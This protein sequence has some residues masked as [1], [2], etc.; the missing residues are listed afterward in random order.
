VARFG[1]I[2]I[3]PR[4]TWPAAHRVVDRIS[5]MSTSSAALAAVTALLLW[6]L[7]AYVVMPAWWERYAKQHPSLDGLPGLT[8]TG[9]GIPG[10]PVNV[11]IAG[12]ENQ[13]RAVFTAAGWSPAD[14]L[15][16]RS[17]ARIAADAVL[18]RPY[19]DAPVSDLYLF[20]RKEDLAF[21]QAS[22]D[23]PRARHHIRFW[24]APVAHPSGAPLWLGSASFDASVGLSHTT[25]QIT[26]HISGDLDAERNHVITSL[27]A[28]GLISAV[29]PVVDFHKV[30]EGRNGG[31]D[32]WHTDGTLMLAVIGSPAAGK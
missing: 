27:E 6:A 7:T 4:A 32:P 1:V 22:G 29:I 25:G 16:L 21:E 10:D 19:A 31:G 8:Q 9:S 11:A 26:H 2:N 15:S 23:S 13:V 28:T 3:K 5:D 20:G 24:R 17:D 14:P 30:R 18:D 12:N